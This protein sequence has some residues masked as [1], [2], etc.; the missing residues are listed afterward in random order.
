MPLNTAYLGRAFPPGETYQVGRE[1]IRRFADAIGDPHPLFRDPHAAREAGH[2]DVV[3]PPTF[4]IAVL[5]RAQDAVLS[6]PELGL[7]FSRVVHRDQR[8]VH[9]RPIVAGDELS[10]TV[11]VE[12]MA[13]LAGNDVLTLR[14]EISDPQGGVCTATTTLV[15]RGA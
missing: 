8:F 7:D 14:V 1:A 15:A 3:A 13:V 5:A 12:A 4:A 10:C 11:H 2:A 9:H 6:D